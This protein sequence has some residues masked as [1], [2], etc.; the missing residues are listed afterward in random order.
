MNRANSIQVRQPW[1]LLHER[2]EQ[3]PKVATKR[4]VER[5]LAAQ[6]LETR[7]NRTRDKIFAD[8]TL[9]SRPYF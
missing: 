8:V 9:C 1:T 5:A 3:K 7:L 4:E 6:P 2:E